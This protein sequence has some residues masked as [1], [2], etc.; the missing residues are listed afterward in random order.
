VSSSVQFLELVHQIDCRD[1]I[2]LFN[3]YRV[4]FNRK[5]W[6]VKLIDSR[7]HHF[8]SM[9][10]RRKVLF[11]WS[12]STGNEPHFFEA[13]NIDS[14]GGNLQTWTHLLALCYSN[15]LSLVLLTCK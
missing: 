7:L 2:A 3:F 8:Q 6:R 10:W 13:K 15:Y 12:G 14:L 1:A 11:V 4:Y 9:V 5:A